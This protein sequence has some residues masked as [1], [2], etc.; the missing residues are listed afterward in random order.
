MAHVGHLEG[1]RDAHVRVLV[2]EEIQRV[3]DLLAGGLGE[4]TKRTFA[5]SSAS[6]G[7]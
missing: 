1:W 5:V 7:P 2:V 6:A 4:H 3:G